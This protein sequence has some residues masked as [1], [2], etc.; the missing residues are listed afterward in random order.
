M[1]SILMLV[2]GPVVFVV[3]RVFGLVYYLLFGWWLDPRSQRKTDARFADEIR[4][5]IPLLFTEYG[6]SIIPTIDPPPR[7]FD[8]AFVTLSVRNVILRFLRSRGDLTVEVAPRDLP[9]E[10]HNLALAAMVIETSQGLGPRK[11]LFD[12]NDVARL[13]RTDFHVL[14]EAFSPQNYPAIKKRLDNIYELSAD[15]LWNAGIELP[16][17]LRTYPLPLKR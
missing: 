1:R 3:G 7:A 13:L 8:A 5:K 4:T 15:D 17:R 10:L 14:N 16:K 6:A 2:L 11:E 12:L 9:S